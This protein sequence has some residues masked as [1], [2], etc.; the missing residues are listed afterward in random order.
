MTRGEG[1]PWRTAAAI[2]L[3]AA[4]LLFPLLGLEASRLSPAGPLSVRLLPVWIALA[5][6][7]TYLAF[8][9]AGTRRGD[10]APPRRWM[11]DGAA[12]PAAF[13]AAW[14]LLAAVGWGLGEKYQNFWVDTLLMVLLGL[15]MNVI[16]GMAGLFV[17]GYAAFYAIGA[18]AH[19]VGSLVLG[20]SFWE[21]LAAGS[22]LAA[23]VGVGVGL[24]SLR[25]RGDY[26]AIAT[27]GLGEAI[28]LAIKNSTALTG[29]TFGC[30]SLEFYR[31][32]GLDEAQA[33]QALDIARGRVIAPPQVLGWPAAFELTHF[34]YLALAFVGVAALLTQRLG[35]SR[36]GR[37]L[38]AVRED[39]LAASA[40]GVP[41]VRV[42]L[43][44]FALGAALAGAAGVL[45]A[46]KQRF[47][48][49]VP[50]DFNLSVLVLSIVVIGGMG[51]V[52]GTAA[53]AVLLMALTQVLR[54]GFDG[55]FQDARFLIYGALMV[56]MMIF[57]PQGLVPERR[58]AGEVARRRDG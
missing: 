31:G 27:L 11:S 45:F 3:G 24:P 25:L 48:D 20:L 16:L 53:G 47:V 50:F 39:E 37:A 13:W 22:L 58:R 41:V 49:P 30:P 17:L 12:H 32:W 33:M 46:A 23:A 18:Y 14:G 26:L 1:S 19:A 7:V 29:G 54:D 15:G 4:A 36:L 40:M 57:R 5:A 38:V 6:A 21:G 8:R 51:S 34:L 9:L 44:A 42:K 35:D 28:R 10:A 55:R 56:A 43:T 2:F 52:S